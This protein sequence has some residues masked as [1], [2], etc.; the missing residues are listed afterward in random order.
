MHDS[1]VTLPGSDQFLTFHF[2]LILSST[3][4]KGDDLWLAKEVVKSG[5]KFYFMRIK[6]DQDVENELKDR[7][8][9]KEIVVLKQL[10]KDC[11]R[12]LKDASLKIDVFL[13]S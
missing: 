1:S 6:I 10:P 13:L 11:D 9:K 8:W 3:R 4:F 12:N 2:F 5:R 7:P